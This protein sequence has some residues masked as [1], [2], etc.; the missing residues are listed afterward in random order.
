MMISHS[1]MNFTAEQITLRNRRSNARA[2]RMGA[3]NIYMV[4]GKTQT[5]SE[6]IMRTGKSEQYLRSLIRK[7]RHSKD[8]II[9]WEKLS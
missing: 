7:I 6:L 9:T 3:Q 1:E 5:M 8:R 2:G 4:S